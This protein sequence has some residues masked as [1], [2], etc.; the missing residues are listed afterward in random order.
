MAEMKPLSVSYD[1]CHELLEL[2][3]PSLLRLEEESGLKWN[4]ESRDKSESRQLG[5]VRVG[6]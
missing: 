1:R 2:C 4:G 3:E 5:G 6:G